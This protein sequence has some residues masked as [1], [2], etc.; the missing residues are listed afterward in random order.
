MIT[1]ERL[2]LRA[3]VPDDWQAVHA[4]CSDPEV[5]RFMLAGEPYTQERSQGYVHGAIMWAQQAPRWNY[6]LAIVLR[7]ENQLIGGCRLGL[8]D[9]SRREADIGFGLNRR[10]WQQGYGTEVVRAMLR[11]GFATLQLH[12]IFAEIFAANT[13][14]YRTLEKAGMRREGHLQEKYWLEGM[15]WD[16]YYYAILERDWAK[17]RHAMQTNRM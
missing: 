5:M 15:W 17:R 4:F 7:A 2:M 1:T 12:R 11:V 9:E 14:S 3:F 10:Y 6:G 16:V 8:A 13:A